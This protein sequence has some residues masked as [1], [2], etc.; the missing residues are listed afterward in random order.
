M[1]ERSAPLPPPPVPVTQV[2][3]LHIA[4]DGPDEVTSTEGKVGRQ[5]DGVPLDVQE[6]WICEDLMFVLQVSN[7][8][9]PKGADIC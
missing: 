5:L 3:A 8:G 9:V 6:A 1:P 2:E 4:Q 7:H